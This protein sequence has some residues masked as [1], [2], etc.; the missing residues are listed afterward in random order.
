MY[1]QVLKLVDVYA[2]FENLTRELGET[3]PAS[4][5]SR[6][7]TFKEKLMNELHDVY[8]FYQP[9]DRDIHERQMLLIPV[10]LKNKIIADQIFREEEVFPSSEVPEPDNVDKHIVYSALKVHNDLKGMKGHEGFNVSLNCAKSIVPESLKTF[11][12]IVSFGLD[13][14]E[15]AFGGEEGD[16]E[17]GSDESDSDT[18]DEQDSEEA[19]VSGTEKKLL[20]IAQDIVYVASHGKKLTPKH[21]GL[22]FSLN[23]SKKLVTLFNRAGH[24]IS[25]RQ[26]LQIDTALANETLNSLDYVT[27]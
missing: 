13:G 3:V 20:S 21:I 7:S 23:R 6:R 25:Y 2:K 19:D 10:K 1:T 8:D 12:T 9:L 16:F 11:L 14:V 17:T 18:D 26:L 4:F 27:G 22:V 24:C 5:E 15:K